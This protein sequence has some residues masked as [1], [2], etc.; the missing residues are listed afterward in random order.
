MQLKLG[1]LLANFQ[2]LYTVTVQREYF[3]NFH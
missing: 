2:E 1:T 3:T